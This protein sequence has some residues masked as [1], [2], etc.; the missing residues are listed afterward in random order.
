V[1]TILGFRTSVALG[2]HALVAAE[3]LAGAS[4]LGYM[5]IEA[6]RY[7]TD[8][9]LLGMI[10]IGASLAS[11]GPSAVRSTGAGYGRPVG[12]APEVSSG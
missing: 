3:M 8:V 12:D 5:T 1:Q 9:M 7:K 11:D 4:G 10:V 2:W 6:V